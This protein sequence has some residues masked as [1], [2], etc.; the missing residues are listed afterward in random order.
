MSD[1]WHECIAEA[2]DDAGISATEKQ[3][4]VV[5]GWVEGAHEN[6]GTA[7][8]H[9]VIPNPMQLEAERLERELKAEREKIACP[10]CKGRGRIITQGPYHSSD[11]D[12]WKC[13]GEGR[14]KP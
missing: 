8:G 5:A 14:V 11:S 9:D 6:Y 2:F 7:H 13:N 10:V 12:C 3:I 4:A 1:Y